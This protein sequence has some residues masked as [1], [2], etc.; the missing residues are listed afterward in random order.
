MWFFQ[1]KRK[2]TVLPR[3]RRLIFD[4]LED[5][6]LLSISYPVD[7]SAVVVDNGTL[8]ANFIP[9]D[10]LTVGADATVDLTP[11]P[12]NP[13]EDM[14]IKN[15]VNNGSLNITGGEKT[16]GTLSGTGNTTVSDGSTLTATSI[17]QNTL[18]IG[19]GATVVIAPIPGGPLP[20]PPSTTGSTP[21][22]ADMSSMI[23]GGT[24][25]YNSDAL[26]NLS[27]V[28]S[29]TLV[30][31]DPPDVKNAWRS[32]QVIVGGD[33]V[34]F[35]PDSD[36]NYQTP[37]QET[38]YE[39]RFGGTIAAQQDYQNVARDETISN[40]TSYWANDSDSLASNTSYGEGSVDNIVVG[41][42]ELTVITSDQGSKVETTNNEN[43]FPIDQT[44]SRNGADQLEI[45]NN[46]GVNE[47][48]EPYFY[49]QYKAGDMEYIDSLYGS[50]PGSDNLAKTQAGDQPA[51][52]S[53][54]VAH[55]TSTFSQVVTTLTGGIAT[56]D[57]GQPTS[58]ASGYD[59][60]LGGPLWLNNV[61]GQDL[62]YYAGHQVVVML[63][64]LKPGHSSCN[65]LASSPISTNAGTMEAWING[66]PNSMYEVGYDIFV[67]TIVTAADPSNPGLGGPPSGGVASIN[68]ADAFGY[69]FDG[70]GACCS[71]VNPIPNGKILKTTY[72][73][74]NGDLVKTNASGN[75]EIVFVS[76]M[77]MRNNGPGLVVYIATIFIDFVDFIGSDAPQIIMSKSLNGGPD[78]HFVLPYTS[79]GQ[80]SL[81]DLDSPDPDKYSSPFEKFEGANI[82]SK[83]LDVISTS[84][85][86]N[87][88]SIF[89]STVRLNNSDSPYTDEISMVK[90]KRNK[91][92]DIDFWNQYV[93]SLGIDTNILEGEI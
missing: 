77:N 10:N 44:I 67:T 73:W 64:G 68:V 3:G 47:Y 91:L 83:S 34:Y 79:T 15:A 8:T 26:P 27:T 13:S 89:K 39:N 5:R 57:Y 93:D 18:T 80:I 69:R 63:F 66:K 48:E 59:K 72:F 75:A 87:Q 6:M 70:S 22:P 62:V 28:N 31:T 50:S 92:M 55:G 37:I 82:Q 46:I 33:P 56:G 88:T 52:V 36:T 51:T 61:P 58:A 16:I 65:T 85:I 21:A 20:L 54:K 38:L 11:L 76:P 42:N 35:P 45:I 71:S 4:Q 12:G 32:T 29:P 90:R 7:P 19:A 17:V 2:N 49:T 78:N 84:I 9:V 1:R 81:S 25:T 40:Q 14:S 53:F 43:N 24:L 60:D 30:C 86:Y 41:S 23:D 74:N